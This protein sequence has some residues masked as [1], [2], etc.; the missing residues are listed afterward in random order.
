MRIVDAN[1]L[2]YAVN[3][4]ASHHEPSR[5]W[6]DGALSGQDRVGLA[7]LPMLAFVRLSTSPRVFPSPL[8]PA[9]AMSRVQEWLRAPSAVVVHPTERHAAILDRLLTASG[10]GGNLTNDAHLA[11]LAVEHRAEIVSYDT[12]FTR[13]REIRCRRPDELL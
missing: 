5:A 9:Q 6:L 7:W 12:D 3:S 11:A 13:F 2:L 10:S 4:R 8:S 1:V